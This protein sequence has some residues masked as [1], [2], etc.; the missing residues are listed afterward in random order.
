M[1]GHLAVDEFRPGRRPA[2]LVC[3]EGPGLNDHTKG[4]AVRLAGLG[5]AAFALDYQGDGQPRPRDEAMAKL[6]VIMA[7]L[8]LTRRLGGPA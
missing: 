1:V 8:D 7:D 3:H 6:G 5:Y 2:V 4:R